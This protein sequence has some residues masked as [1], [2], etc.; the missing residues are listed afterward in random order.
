MNR[1]FLYTMLFSFAAVICEAGVS[2]RREI[3][4]PDGKEIVVVNGKVGYGDINGEMRRI[5]E[6]IENLER[7]MRKVDPD[8][9]KG[10]SMEN[11]RE[12]LSLKFIHEAQ[13]FI[14]DG[15]LK[16]KDKRST[17]VVLMMKNET[18]FLQKSLQKSKD[19]PYLVIC[20]PKVGHN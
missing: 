10:I 3:K 8:S 16:N 6:D 7:K 20:T 2:A 18:E 19:F 14:L 12:L 15:G 17:K 11:E 1:F 5:E 4:L 9:K 13:K